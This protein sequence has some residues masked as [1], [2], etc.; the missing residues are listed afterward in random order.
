MKKI[1]LLLV[2]DHPIVLDGLRSFLEKDPAIEIVGAVH[3]GKAAL[4]LLEQQ[5]ADVVILDVSMPGDLDG[6][7]TATRIRKLY[8]DAK[9]VLLTMFGEGRYIEKALQIGI[10]GYV[11]KDKNKETLMTAIRTVLAGG[12]NRYYSPD[13]LA[14]ISVQSA[15][16]TKKSDWVRLTKREKEIICIMAKE[17]Q[18]TAEQVAQQLNIATYT[19]QTH[20]SNAKSKLDMSKSSELVKYVTENGLCE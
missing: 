6:L 9:I 11:L 15:T 18:L 20:I 17:P 3:S 14:R 16:S 1:N 7:D 19:V 8:P 12:D 10:H 13:V 4:D 2:D 5:M